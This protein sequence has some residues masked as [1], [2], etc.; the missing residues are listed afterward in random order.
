MF[1]AYV[2]RD[3]FVF[4]ILKNLLELVALFCKLPLLQL[5]RFSL[6]SFSLLLL[7]IKVAGI[8]YNQYMSSHICDKCQSFY[9]TVEHGDDV[10]Y[11]S[12]EK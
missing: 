11:I 8:S 12:N 10:K 1:C 5:F 3:N 7:V 9:Q 4:K 2:V 6:C